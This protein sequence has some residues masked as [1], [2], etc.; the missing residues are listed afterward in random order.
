MASAERVKVAILAGGLGS[1]L[2]ALTRHLPK[3]MI[4]VGGKPFLEHV[5]RSF[6]ARNLTDIV[7]MTGHFAER[8]EEYFGDGAHFGVKI[9]YS[10]EHEPIGT[11]GAVH[12]ARHLLGDRF[13]L[14]YGDVFRRFDYDRFV[15]EHDRPCLAAYRDDAGN[16][17]VE[18][19]K[20]TRF[21]KKARLSYMDA[22]FCVMPSSVIDFLQP[23]G[24]FEETVFPRLAA[25]G[26]FDCEIV[27]HD[28]VEIGTADALANAR[29][30]LR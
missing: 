28:F 18:D 24:S 10:R 12:Q 20:V 6:S 8:I 26:N 11:G 17:D 2:G 1:R 30:V 27:D 4:D 16:T 21:D 9:A 3:P 5:I 23:S 22:G 7:L 29:K 15:S 25:S 19:G 14:T 13:L